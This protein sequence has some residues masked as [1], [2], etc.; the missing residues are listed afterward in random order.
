MLLTLISAFAFAKAD[1]GIK[2]EQGSWAVITAKAKVEKKLIFI[3]CFT[4]WCGPCKQLSAEIF[5]QLAV[6]EHFNQNFIN[7]KVDMEK[8]EGIELQKKF[9]IAA[10]PTLLWVD[11]EGNV[12]HRAVGF[13]KAEQL[14]AEAK[15]A[16]SGESPLAKLEKQYKK[17]KKNPDVVYAYLKSLT[18]TADSRA[19]AIAEY[20]LSLIPKHRYLDAEI[21]TLIS[22]HV[23][24]PFSPAFTYIFEHRSDFD[25]KFGASKIRLSL[26]NV[27]ARYSYLLLSGITKGKGFDEPAFQKFSALLDREGYSNR[28]MLIETTK[29]NVFLYQK[30]WKNYAAK[31]DALIADGLYSHVV[32]GISTGWYQKIIESD[33]ND[34]EVLKSAL[35]WV[36]LSFRNDF[37]FSM[38]YLGKMFDAKVKLLERMSSSE[39][40]KKTKVEQALLQQLELKQLEYNKQHGE[41]MKKLQ[42]MTIM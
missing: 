21:F 11:Q 18:E 9:H 19:R 20:Y 30:D 15:K 16:L 40:L 32:G 2:F 31:I 17:D 10:Y 41:R 38:A 37:T 5:P 1:P 24:S 35:S 8:G 27:Y 33:C 29:V 13:M 25:R 4:A 36:E 28:R 42:E 39:E 3:D 26:D 7:Y 12:V 22:K 34:P 6:A 23:E 14:I